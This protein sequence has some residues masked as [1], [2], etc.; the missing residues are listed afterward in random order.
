MD[1]MDEPTADE[2]EADRAAVAEIALK[3][4][5]EQAQ[6][7]PNLADLMRSRGFDPEE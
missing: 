3:L 6:T 7:D 2:L 4:L 5:R 1:G